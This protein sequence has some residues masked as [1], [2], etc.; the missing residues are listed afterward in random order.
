VE[1]LEIKI[2]VSFI[3]SY[4]RERMSV[5]HD[6]KAEVTKD[7]LRYHF[8]KGQEEALARLRDALSAYVEAETTKLPPGELDPR[9]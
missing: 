8:L 9:D 5:L 2:E 7:S 6:L 1:P 4:I 3:R